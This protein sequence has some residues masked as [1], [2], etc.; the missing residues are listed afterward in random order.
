MTNKVIDLHSKKPRGGGGD[1][2]TEPPKISASQEMMIEH[3]MDYLELADAGGL[4]ALAIVG[5]SSSGRCTEPCITT[6]GIDP[7]FKLNIML[8]EATKAA[9]DAC[10]NNLIPQYDDEDE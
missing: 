9:E 8:S 3:L 6:E 10:L 1:G 7:M 2:P 4:S 5:I